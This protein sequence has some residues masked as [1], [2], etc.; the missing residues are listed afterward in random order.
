MENLMLFDTTSIDNTVKMQQELD[1]TGEGQK[2]MPGYWKQAGV[3]YDQSKLVDYW[4]SSHNQYMK[5]VDE[6]LKTSDM[7]DED[8]ATV[9][10]YKDRKMQY[11]DDIL[12]NTYDAGDWGFKEGVVHFNN[13]NGMQLQN[14][15]DYMEKM[16][17]YALSLKYDN[18]LDKN[19]K[20]KSVDETKKSYIAAE[21]QLRKDDFFTNFGS[22]VIGNVG[23]YLTDPVGATTLALEFATLGAI[24]PLTLSIQGAKAIKRAEQVKRWYGASKVR[25]DVGA[26]IPAEH[27]ALARGVRVEK[28]NKTLIS[29]NKDK[30][31]KLTG[32]ETAI[33]GGSEAIQQD[34]TF[35]FKHEVLP[36][37][38]KFDSNL[39]IGL[40]AGASGLMSFV[41]GGISHN[42]Y[43]NTFDIT[44]QDG[45]RAVEETDEL[46]KV[47]ESASTI[48]DGETKTDGAQDGDAFSVTE[49]EKKFED[50][51]NIQELEQK[52]EAINKDMNDMI[53]EIQ[54]CI[55]KD[56]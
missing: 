56:I 37:F 31:L 26:S 25:K 46:F 36:H 39:Q 32:A 13:T 6:S 53:E 48:K 4:S 34:L 47:T 33:G 21:T 38:T 11:E 18:L 54:K 51:D 17:G 15:P 52:Q 22:Q 23:A 55:I 44:A 1:P 41:G 49:T 43:K 8:K 24:K 28:A 2:P 7:S 19:L 14:T 10:F 29:V 42:I 20:T 5:Q 40:V 12:R 50:I 27:V 30:M 3:A 45:A 9:R 16:R 35:E